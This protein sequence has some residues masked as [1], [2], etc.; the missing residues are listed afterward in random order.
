MNQDDVD[1]KFV[2]KN[3]K[4]KIKKQEKHKNNKFLQIKIT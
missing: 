2:I 4:K 1:M 3:K